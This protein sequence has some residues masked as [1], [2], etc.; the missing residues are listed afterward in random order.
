MPKSGSGAYRWVWG[1]TQDRWTY[2]KEQ[3]G[4]N[5]LLAH[6]LDT[7]ATARELWDRYLPDSVRAV[8]TEAFGGGDAATARA[9]VPF[10]AAV[11]DL[12]KAA[13]V[14]LE[15]FDQ[16]KDRS[17]L[18]D[19]RALW[20][21]EARSHG[22]P[23]PDTWEGLYWALH[24]HITA[25]TLP[26]LL[27]CDCPVASGERCRAPEHQ[28]LHDVAYA[29]GGHHG[30]VPGADTVG[31]AA[32]ARGGD[33][34]DD[35]RADLVRVTAGLL[36]VDLGRLAAVVAPVKPAAL[37]H[38]MGLVIMSDW[39]AS[40]D[41]RYPYAD[42]DDADGA[43]WQAAQDRAEAALTALCLDRWKPTEVTWQELWPGTEPRPMQ[44]AVMELMPSTGQALVVVEAPPASGKTRLGLWCAHHLAVRNGYQGLYVAMPTKAGA[45]R[46]ADE[47]R[48]FMRA[49]VAEGDATLAVVHATPLEEQIVYGMT[50]AEAQPGQEDS[51]VDALAAGGRI[52][53]ESD[54]AERDPA[55][56]PAAG[57][58]QGRDVAVMDPW[59]LKR[60]VGLMAT[61][62]VGTVDEVLLA[63]QPSRH[64]MLRLFGL[65]CKTVII[66]E[67]HAY[68]LYQQDLLSTAV[69][70]LA[71]AGASVVV[72]SNALPAAVRT[73]LTASWCAGLRV[74]ASD[75]GGE[76]PATVVDA[77][78]GIRRGGLPHAEAP[79]A[80]ATVRLRCDGEDPAELASELLRRA[81]DGGCVGAVRNQVEKAVALYRAAVAGAALHGWDTSEIVLLH[82]QFQTH[83][84]KAIEDRIHSL[85]GEGASSR[86]DRL[87]VITTQAALQSVDFDYMV[88]DLAPVDLLVERLGSLH[89]NAE[90]TGQR[91]SWCESAQLD[92]FSRADPEEPE[93]PLVE[94]PRP[95]SGRR[96]GNPDGLTYAPYALAAT[97]RTLR[98]RRDQQGRI[99][100]SLPRDVAG[101]VASV[102]ESRQTDEGP[103]GA[104]LERTWNAWEAALSAERLTAEYNGV[105]PYVEDN[106]ATV[107]WLISGGLNGSGDEGGVEGL[108]ALPRLSVPPVNAVC[109]YRHGGKLLT[110]D[111]EGELKAELYSGSQLERGVSPADER[112]VRRKLL[113]H[114]VSM[115]AA[116]FKG[117]DR[118]PSP[119]SW[120]TQRYRPLDR[121]A[122]LLFDARGTCV[123][124]LAGQVRYDPSTGLH[125]L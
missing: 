53:L 124:G 117:S 17:H 52:A 111:A 67:A 69:E 60:C 11:H 96:T 110:Y 1:K 105:R 40:N 19:A 123:S 48:R 44:A 25:A 78:G 98:N 116:W 9:V 42:L 84:Q 8:L 113:L 12:G 100:L 14:F 82:E 34:W 107:A 63:A 68:E 58:P 16:E 3:R 4:W 119:E 24:Q 20:E 36:G 29:L 92:V 76:G 54:E 41:D 90:N 43:W 102:Y 6:L 71:D 50:D 118:L 18:H 104:L 83:R 89:R 93:L 77:T 108:R 7:G 61:F 95:R 122:V 2:R 125:R 75:A 106:P 31:T 32:I 101:L 23:L 115:P 49:A 103:W 26:R 13:P 72:L 80:V 88:S 33:D 46:I 65:S 51:P 114:T 27:G 79:Q 38:L 5:P 10:L 70:W 109:L 91:P 99:S 30:H 66:D 59:Y 94:P 28:G 35:V 97:F 22:V 21:E 57:A 112:R 121:Y 37:I 62:G 87:L 45:G 39:I 47:V 64:W 55:R 73:A 81:R 56:N 120:P 85:L 74:E 86:P 15:L